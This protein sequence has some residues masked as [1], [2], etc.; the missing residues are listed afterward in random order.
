M[1]VSTAITFRSGPEDAELKYCVSHSCETK[2]E[3]KERLSQ[4]NLPCLVIIQQIK[5]CFL[6]LNVVMVNGRY[7]SNDC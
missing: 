5:K 3:R 7:D 6:F 4:I 2:H 1:V